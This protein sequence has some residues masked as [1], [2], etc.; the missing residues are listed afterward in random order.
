MDVTF[1]HTD[2]VARTINAGMLAA[3][4]ALALLSG[5]ASR[6]AAPGKSGTFRPADCPL[7]NFPGVP[8]ADLGPNYS[9]GYLTVP[10]NRRAPN[11]RTI[12][13][14]VA[15]V[16]AVSSAPRPD[17]IVFLA[18]GPGGAG[19]L[20]APGV[21]AGGMNANREIIFVNQRGTLHSFPHLSCR[22][23]DDLSARSIGL[24]YQAASTAALDA[25]AV[26]ACRERI[27]PTGADLAAYNTI[28]NAADI[29]DLRVAL[30]IE[31]WNV[32]GV[33]YGTDLALQL[34]RDHPEGIRSVVLDSVVPPNQNL[35][36][37][38]WEAPASGLTA[39]F[40]ACAAQPACA[41]AYPNLATDF[42]AT[43]NRLSATPAEITVEDAA[44]KPVRV[45]VDGFKLVPIVLAWS[46]SAT[47]VVDIPRMIDNLANGDG[48]L[49]AAA[50][51]ATNDLPEAQRG[52]L[53]AGLALG[54]Y[55]QEMANWT[56]PDRELSQARMAMPGIPD[57]VLQ[58]MP[59]G[60]WLFDECRAWGL[61]RSD[62]ASLAPATSAVPTLILAGT[63][64]S[65][66]APAWVDQVTPGLSHSLV[67]HFPGVGHA[68]LPTSHCAQ[69]IMTAF[70]D[71][72][73]A[74]VDSAC[75]GETSI[76]TFT[77]SQSK[78]A[79]PGRTSAGE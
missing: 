8:D 14:L 58:I 57:A 59:T 79:T 21:V 29:A 38:W 55:C 47:Q 33:S 23:M 63:F 17:P 39:I 11:G 12:R 44:G 40:A 10:E 28:E 19:T 54:A 51:V 36:D 68:V 13:I 31:Q 1:S 78:T 66:T 41:A 43:V 64:D 77:T 67:R 71:D 15:R 30:G 56:D 7:P 52:L 18:G 45:T 27:A 34:L 49:A 2:R 73:S 9:C 72:P 70:L 74:A 24:V 5:C 42:T 16:K 62:P 50:I 32:Y 37:K 4:S 60:S 22:E 35:V 26:T 53:G 46:A 6:H 76:P 69:A 65:S 3:M 48:R 20:S 25:A 75:I 61:G